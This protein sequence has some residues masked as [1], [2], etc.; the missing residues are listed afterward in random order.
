MS[1]YGG[2]VLKLTVSKVDMR[3]VRSWKVVL[4]F[5]WRTRNIVYLNCP[6][7]L[8]SVGRD[9]IYARSSNLDHHKKK[10]GSMPWWH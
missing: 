3:G 7:E 1:D 9:I 5:H 4:C 8:N 6:R 10:L 2:Y